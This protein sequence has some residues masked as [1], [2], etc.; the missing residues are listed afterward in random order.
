MRG[1]NYDIEDDRPVIGQCA[2]CGEDIHGGTDGYESDD[3]YSFEWM[4]DMVCDDCLRDYCN[5]HFRNRD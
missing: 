4:G 5:R 1:Y 2:E 3:Y